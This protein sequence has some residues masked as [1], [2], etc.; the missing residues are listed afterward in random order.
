MTIFAKYANPKEGREIER[1]RTAKI[2][3]AGNYYVVDEIN[4]YSYG[5][6]IVLANYDYIFNS[7]FFD[8][9][10]SDGE[11][12]DIFQNLEYNNYRRKEETDVTEDE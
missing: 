10:N 7:V 9:Y 12:I 2:L 5:T 6:D 3:T 4:I 11:K 1:A 8:F